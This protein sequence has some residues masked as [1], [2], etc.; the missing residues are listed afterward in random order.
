MKT[1]SLFF[2]FG[3]IVVSIF[4][5][6]C[7]EEGNGEEQPEC[8]EG[9]TKEYECDDGTM[10]PWCTCVDEEWACTVYPDRQCPEPLPE[11]ECYSD[12]DCMMIGFICVDG[13]CVNDIPEQLESYCEYDEGVG[14]LDFTHHESLSE[15]RF[16]YRVNCNNAGYLCN[17]M[18]YVS[19]KDYP[20]YDWWFH[21]M[22]RPKEMTIMGGKCT[23]PYY[24]SEKVV[25]LCEAE[26]SGDGSWASYNAIYIRST[27]QLASIVLSF[28]NSIFGG[29]K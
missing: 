15:N 23:M 22:D 29:I 14:T 2:I 8:T 28:L 11:P 26:C 18:T 9:G 12:N 6:G 17:E 27:G 24:D 16:G 25:I 20:I 4:I 1:K 13:E 3:L 19:P 7:T 10:V 5:S 21:G